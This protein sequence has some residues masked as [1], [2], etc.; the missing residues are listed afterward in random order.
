M[1]GSSASPLNK[2]TTFENAAA[3][4]DKFKGDI[5]AGK[6]VDQSQLISAAKNFQD[7]SQALNGSDSKFF[8]DFDA[9]RAL[10]TKA[11][12]NIDGAAAT[13]ASGVATNLPASPFATDA[14]QAAL[15]NLASQSVA[16]TQ[17]QTNALGAKLDQLISAVN[18]N[19]NG[20]GY[21]LQS[22]VRQLPGF[23]Q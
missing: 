12:A 9:L 1:V 14:V 6:V 10:I 23:S 3:E 2:K 16:A 4:L 5:N 18:D 15:G 20:G 11:A 19:G 22:S 13:T 7:A 8:D 17:A 21:K